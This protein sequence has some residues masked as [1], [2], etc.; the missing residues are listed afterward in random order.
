MSLLQQE[1]PRSKKE[2][3]PQIWLESFKNSKNSADLSLTKVKYLSKLYTDCLTQQ[4]QFS[5]TNLMSDLY[6]NCLVSKNLK[7][8]GSNLFS[9]RIYE[10]FNLM[11]KEPPITLLCKSTLTEKPHEAQ[12]PLPTFTLY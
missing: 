7:N 4:Y 10:I 12:G 8:N 5:E 9:L 3:C 11:L 2:A 1:A 6:L